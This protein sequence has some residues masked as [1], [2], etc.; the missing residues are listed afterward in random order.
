MSRAWWGRS[1]L[2]RVDEGVEARLLLQR[3]WRAAGLV[4]S[5]LSVRCMRSCRPFCSGWPGLDALEL[6]AQAQPPD[7][8]L[9]EAIERRRRGEGDAVVR[10]DRARQAELLKQPL[11]DGE[12]VAA[13]CVVE[14]ASHVSR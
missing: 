11:E 10:P 7:R 12:R 9:A 2:N 1:W 8:Q 14:S 5:R 6:N 4:A 3:R 13:L